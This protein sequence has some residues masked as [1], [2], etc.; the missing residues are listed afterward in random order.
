MIIILTIIMIDQ[1]RDFIADKV[2]K[3]MFKAEHQFRFDTIADIEF[4]IRLNVLSGRNKFDWS[5]PAKFGYCKSGKIVIGDLSKYRTEEEKISQLKH[6]AK[7]SFKHLIVVFYS[8]EEQNVSEGQ[9]NAEAPDQEKDPNN[10]VT[11]A[12]SDHANISTAT[13]N[14]VASPGAK[15]DHDE[16]H[17]PRYPPSVTDSFAQQ[18]AEIDKLCVI[19]LEV[20]G[21]RGFVVPPG[22]EHKICMVC[23]DRLQK[24][25]KQEDGQPI[26]C[27][28]CKTVIFPEYDPAASSSSS[29]G[30]SAPHRVVDLT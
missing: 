24:K 10:K 11:V 12:V 30:S 15:D 2:E 22:C 26:L 28:I 20:L 17:C 23:L 6:Y 21:R 8:E 9:C 25:H 1:R 16:Q 14:A 27:P 18:N 5:I 7:T 4:D 3:G 19:C 29:S 13:P